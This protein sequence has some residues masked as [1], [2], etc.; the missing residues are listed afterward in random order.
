ECA[1][2]KPYHG[3]AFPAAE[4]MIAMNTELVADAPEL[5]AFFKKWDWSAGNQLAAEGWYGKNKT[6]LKDAGRSSEEIY[7][8]TGIWYLK[9]NDAWKDWVPHEVW[10]KVKVAL[11]KEE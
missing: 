7:S 9:N 3:C 4:I 10:A 2:N 8:A 11:E 6:V 5:I 1:D